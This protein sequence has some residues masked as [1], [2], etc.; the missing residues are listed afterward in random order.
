MTDPFRLRVVKRITEVLEGT[1]TGTN[2]DGSDKHELVG[3]VYRGR[4]FL[5]DDEPLPCITILEPRQAIE[6]LR[7]R[8]RDNPVQ[9]GEWDLY[10][11]AGSMTTSA[12]PVIL[13]MCLLHRSRNPLA[14]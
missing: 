2:E 14:T 9:F 13:P 11:Q 3:N 4:G 5:S 10:I 1:V 7:N 8:G 12:I 6:Q